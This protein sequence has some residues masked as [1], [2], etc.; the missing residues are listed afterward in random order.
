MRKTARLLYSS[1]I[2][3]VASSC[4]FTLLACT[5]ANINVSSSK[6]G[7][8][9][10]NAPYLYS[11]DSIHDNAIL[12]N[13][14]CKTFG[15]AAYLP[16]GGPNMMAPAYIVE[17]E[18]KLT[19]S[20]SGGSIFTDS[21]SCQADTGASSSISAIIQIGASKPAQNFWFFKST[22]NGAH[23]LSLSSDNSS[24]KNAKIN[25]TV[26][27]K[28]I[29]INL[30]TSLVK[31]T[32]Y[33]IE[34][35]LYEANGV[36][37]L[38]SSS[39]ITY[40][41]NSASANLSITS[42]CT[43]LGTTS[44]INIAV[45]QSRSTG[46][47]FIKAPSSGSQ[48]LTAT[49]LPMNT[50]A[51][52]FT[53]SI[54]S[55]ENVIDGLVYRLNP[56]MYN[57]NSN[58]NPNRIRPGECR[59]LDITLANSFGVQVPAPAANYHISISA[60][61][62]MKVV[63][64]NDSNCN[65]SL[66]QFANGALGYFSDKVIFN[67][68]KLTTKIFF[69][70]NSINVSGSFYGVQHGSDLRP[71]SVIKYQSPA[72][73]ISASANEPYI[74]A[75]LFDFWK[76]R[77]I[78]SH[79]FSPTPKE[80]QINAPAGMTIQC[81]VNG[82]TPCLN[83]NSSTR[84]LTFSSS[85]EFFT[86]NYSFSTASGNNMPMAM[87][88]FSRPSI[89]PELS[90]VTCGSTVPPSTTVS[91]NTAMNSSYPGSVV[92]FSASSVF[93]PNGLYDF[94]NK[95]FIGWS[96]MT[97]QINVGGSNNSLSET[98]GASSTTG[99]SNMKIVSS[100][101]GGSYVIGLIGAITVS[102]IYLDNLLIEHNGATSIPAIKISSSGSY[103]ANLKNIKIIHSG[104]GWDAFDFYPGS[105]T[106]LFN[107]EKIDLDASLGKSVSLQTN[108]SGARYI[109]I[110]D[111]YF[112]SKGELYTYH[113][114]G[115]S[116]IEIRGSTFESMGF[117]SGQYINMQSSTTI[118]AYQN[119]LKS[120]NGALLVYVNG[121]TAILNAYDNLFAHS[122]ANHAILSSATGALNFDRNHFVKPSG[123]NTFSVVGSSQNTAYNSASVTSNRVCSADA[124]VNKWSAINTNF[125]ATA[126]G[127]FLS[128]TNDTSG[129]SA[130]GLCK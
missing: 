24:I 64:F 63:F 124:S 32:C 67:P 84:R 13:G 22:T 61:A 75:D 81:Q 45:S 78:G 101:S 55:G 12:T 128:T 70:A 88:N 91:S 74:Y 72:Y 113:T 100:M 123:G 41:L 37:E 127:M 50:T 60:D 121:G 38:Q 51:D 44:N 77:V 122:G 17:K 102:N 27:P 30:P 104:S 59:G 34:A 73:D 110:R 10:N 112:G 29:K 97:S 87:Y 129:F 116:D 86:N 62:N 26:G 106:Q 115:T 39:A 96:D 76:M 65:T 80:L 33:P 120:T 42:T 31:D 23:S 98:A 117:T 56:S 16:G 9:G 79:E 130:T 108:T 47:N 4:L 118:N 125:S 99:L 19:I 6:Q 1:I 90:S 7:S 103:N 36:N 14:V 107:L 68:N 66:K 15:V 89:Y 52:D 40:T 105:G 94:A 58:S 83:F 43:G 18:T 53:F 11:S 25:F 8:G 111:S 69:I 109:K 54:G 46:P 3:V 5:N 71:A 57:N 82:T 126:T 20:V 95:T 119:S 48:T 49:L 85:A 35:I 92:C 114:A 2:I 21:A 28:I 93:T